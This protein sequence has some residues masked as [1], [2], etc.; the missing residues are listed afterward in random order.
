MLR[1]GVQYLD[2]YKYIQAMLQKLRLW[3]ND[4]SLLLSKDDPGIFDEFGVPKDEVFA[5]L[6]AGELDLDLECNNILENMMHSFIEVTERQLVDFLPDGKYGKEPDGELRERMK[7]SKL[8]N[9]LSE[10]EFGDLDFSYYKRRNASLFYY[11]GVQMVKR[12]KTLSAW[13]SSKSPSVQTSLLK[14]A[15]AKSR[16][17]RLKHR[18]N[19]MVVRKQ[20]LERLEKNH[21]TKQQKKAAD[22]ALKEKCGACVNSHGGPCK[23][24]EDVNKVLSGVKFKKDIKAIIRDEYCTKVLGHKDPR[25]V[26]GSKTVEKL[27]ADFMSFLSEKSGLPMPTHL[28]ELDLCACSSLKLHTS[29]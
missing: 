20:H 9:L 14:M 23:T 22:Q 25:L 17:I 4:A 16:E 18:N 1:G 5:N 12:N 13:L 29:T 19:E 3:A 8:T 6:F 2:Q 24:T 28:A 21:A 27:K 7:H 10:N 26:V 11:S 15:R